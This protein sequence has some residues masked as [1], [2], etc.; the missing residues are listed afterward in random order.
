M[1][2]GQRLRRLQQR[3][4]LGAPALFGE[5]RR[6]ASLRIFVREHCACG[7]VAQHHVHRVQRSSPHGEVEGRRAVRVR[8][9][10][11]Q[12]VLDE[13]REAVAGVLVRRPVQGGV[14]AVV[15]SREVRPV[16]NQ[17]M[18][19]QAELPLRGEH[20]GSLPFR[21]RCVDVAAGGDEEAH[22][23]QLPLGASPVERLHAAR[24]DG[25]IQRHS[26]AVEQ[27]EDVLH[28]LQRRPVADCGAV[29]VRSAEHKF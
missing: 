11:L 25:E 16:L 22:G 12:A 26:L 1:E 8:I 3:L 23:L 18:Q 19:Q 28:A 5:H 20:Q 27:G 13:H 10:R 6:S 7:R 9:L 2:R 17:P 29:R 15:R 21:L 4:Q 14:S 24:G